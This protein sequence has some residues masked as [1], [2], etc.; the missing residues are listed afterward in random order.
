MK[1]FVA[2]SKKN[3]SAFVRCIIKTKTVLNFHLQANMK[4]PVLCVCMVVLLALV[5]AAA[6]PPHP[7][8]GGGPAGQRPPPPPPNATAASLM[9]QSASNGKACFGQRPP[10]KLWF[11]SKC[12]SCKFN[13]HSSDD[14]FP[15]S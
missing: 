4:A 3:Y 10:S 5:Y 13:K 6:K 11:L 15:K 7:P 2:S 12:F 1:K 9:H 14:C 8:P